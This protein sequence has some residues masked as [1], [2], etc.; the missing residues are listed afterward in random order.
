M[1]AQVLQNEA[2]L[3]KCELVKDDFLYL[4]FQWPWVSQEATGEEKKDGGK[5][6]GKDGGK[7]GGKKK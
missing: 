3:S 6:G 5:K 4:D 2:L 7:K 1:G